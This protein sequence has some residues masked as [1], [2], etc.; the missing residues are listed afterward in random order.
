MDDCSG[1]QGRNCGACNDPLNMVCGGCG[2]CVYCKDRGEPARYI[3]Y[4][5]SR[6]GKRLPGSFGAS[7]AI[8][9]YTDADLRKRLAAAKRDPDLDVRVRDLRKERR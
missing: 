8:A 4:G 5:V 9:V 1:C 7:A 2:T 6:S 3:L